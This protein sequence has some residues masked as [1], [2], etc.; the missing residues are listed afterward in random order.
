MSAK[1]RVGSLREDTFRE[2]D[3]NESQEKIGGKKERKRERDEGEGGGGRRG[4]GN[5]EQD[6]LDVI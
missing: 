6:A 4:M 3:W 1:L 2:S 5:N